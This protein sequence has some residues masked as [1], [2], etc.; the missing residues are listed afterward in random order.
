MKRPETKSFL[1]TPCNTDISSHLRPDAERKPSLDTDLNDSNGTFLTS[2]PMAN[3][4]FTH[5]DTPLLQTAGIASGPPPLPST[6]SISFTDLA[7]WFSGWELSEGPHPHSTPLS[8]SEQSDT[9][10]RPQFSSLLAIRHRGLACQPHGRPST[11]LLYRVPP[12]PPCHH[13]HGRVYPGR[14]GPRL[15]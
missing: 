9:H 10:P 5:F 1:I 14:T 8:R 2:H 15:H 13:R 7:P 3:S 4:L 12:P 11:D 6:P